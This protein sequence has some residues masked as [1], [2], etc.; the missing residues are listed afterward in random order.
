MPGLQAVLAEASARRCSSGLPFNK[1]QTYGSGLWSLRCRAYRP[2]SPKRL[3]E[4][5]ARSYPSIA[6]DLQVW[7]FTSVP[8]LR[9]LLA[10]ASARRCSSVFHFGAWLTGLVLCSPPVSEPGRR[11]GCQTSASRKEGLAGMSKWRAMM[12]MW[13]GMRPPCVRWGL[14]VCLAAFRCM[15]A[16]GGHKGVEAKRPA[17]YPID[18][19]FRGPRTCCSPEKE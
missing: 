19:N 8:G 17:Q 10:E 15:D 7:S 14:A 3:R 5:A 9:A 11:S 12:S 2:C 16:S 13:F 4:G 1:R 18:G 6:P